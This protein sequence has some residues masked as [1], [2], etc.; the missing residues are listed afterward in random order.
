VVVLDE[1]H[2][3]HLE[4]DLALA[5]LR[6]LQD[7]QRP[8]LRLVVM[9]ATLDASPLA[10]WLCAPVL[11]SE[12]K[13]FPLDVA[14]TPHSAL[15][16]EER[17]AGALEKLLAEGVGGDVL[18]FLPGAAE[19]RRAA[20]AVGPL[21]QR[22]DLLALPLHGDLPPDQQDRAVQPAARRKVIL[23]TNVAESSVTIE[24][25]RA[26]ID[27]GLA[28]IA[29]DS[30][31]TGLP[32]LNRRRIS[33][34]SAA[35]RAGRAGRTGP[36]RVIRLYTQEELLRSPAQEVPEIR[37]RELGQLLL[38]LHALGHAG[39]AGLGWLEAPPP[40]AV[41]AAEALLKRLEAIDAAGRFTR[42]GRR[43][44]GLPLDPRLSRLVSYAAE[45]GALELGCAAAAL[46]SAGDRL[47]ENHGQAAQSD[48]LVLLDAPRRPT[49]ARLERQIRRSY[50]VKR[51][52]RAPVEAEDDILRKAVLVA[53]PDRLARR[54]Q[55]NEF[56]L[57][58]PAG[59]GP[60]LLVEESAVR[61]ARFVVAVDVEQRRDKGPPLIRLASAIEP[62]WLLDLFPDGLESKDSVEW[63]RAAERVTAVSQLVFDGLV[64]EES[65]GGRVDVESAAQL[66]AEKALEAGLARFTDV[67][68][69][70]EY[71]ARV[72]FACSAA[73]AKAPPLAALDD[74]AVRRALES[75]CSG[76]RS[77]TELEAVS[78][79][80]GLLRALAAG[81]PAN[82]GR[83]LDEL[84][85]A[86]LRLPSGRSARVRYARNQA[87]WLASRLQD[88]FG[89]TDTPRVG[90]G[91]TPVVLHLLAPNQRPVQTTTD[92]AGFWQRLYPKL[93]RE[94]GRRYPKHAWPENPYTALQDEK[95]RSRT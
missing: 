38:D 31:W 39:P 4:S 13:L 57:S 77:F 18:V 24:G 49:T 82:A 42:L 52:R 28:R 91:K 92:L 93:R 68:E 53:F 50:P 25:V 56:V 21:A 78:R 23:S 3:R 54:R 5:L 90:N 12:G 73:S 43:M 86:R 29:E 65:R 67:A 75:L 94:L 74:D 22:H 27:S 10:A 58:A 71:R 40:A 60:A 26:V 7:T 45:Q 59:G 84:A 6:H 70:D 30:P 61:D 85:P 33:Q 47:P 35:Q 62:D 81:L 76:L 51:R 8:D 19:I 64:I 63:D 20:R 34:A 41:Q 83:W 66:L 87:P 37:R 11:R 80:G 72:A 9:S 32:T 15:P 17:V 36:G 48:L 69:L 2:E 14:Y 44:A 46:L 95:S 89:W 55:A 1:F 79:D 88:F 16:L